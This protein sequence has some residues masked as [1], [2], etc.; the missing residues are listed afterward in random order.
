MFHTN[1]SYIALKENFTRISFC[2]DINTV[3]QIETGYDDYFDV[4]LNDQGINHSYKRIFS[5][6]R[7]DENFQKE[8]IDFLINNIEMC[9]DEYVHY[10]P[11]EDEYY[12]DNEY[13]DNENEEVFIKYIFIVYSNK[14]NRYHINLL[15][16]F[17]FIEDDSSRNYVI[18][19]YKRYIQDNHSGATR[20]PKFFDSLVSNN[21]LSDD[22][23]LMSL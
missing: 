23:N 11:D 15:N 21:K 7:K 4:P 5:I 13:N 20:N 16:I 14:K 18:S 6:T 10:T 9:S 8:L 12:D 22:D 17:D 3:Y 1:I 2:K 19:Q